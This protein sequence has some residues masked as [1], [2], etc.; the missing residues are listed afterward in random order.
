MSY[1]EEQKLIFCGALIGV[2][3]T[4]VGFYVYKVSPNP[5]TSTNAENHRNF[6]IVDT[7]SYENRTCSVIRY[8]TPS[9]SWEYFLDCRW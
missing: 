5:P 3:F 1:F 8:T 4:L 7:Y 9:T 6:E 2:A